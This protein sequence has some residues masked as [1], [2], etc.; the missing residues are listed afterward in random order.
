MP[1]QSPLSP[2]LSRHRGING[3]DP[4]YGRVPVYAAKGLDS[5]WSSILLPFEGSS[6]PA[7]LPSGED[8]GLGGKAPSLLPLK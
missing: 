4:S 5:I 7:L 6:I 1:I 2:V 8:G 3:R